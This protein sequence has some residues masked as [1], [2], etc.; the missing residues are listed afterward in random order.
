MIVDH[1]FAQRA[2]RGRSSAFAE[3]AEPEEVMALLRDYHA[4]L[5]P[6]VALKS[7]HHALIFWVKNDRHSLGFRQRLLE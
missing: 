7:K 2:E 6:I 1:V 3:R 5:G 4:A